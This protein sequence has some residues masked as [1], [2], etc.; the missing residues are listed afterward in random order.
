[1]HFIQMLY[2]FVEARWP[3]D[4]AVRVRGLAGNIV[5]CSWAINFTLTVPLSAQVYKCLSTNL[6]LGVTLRWTIL[7]VA[8]C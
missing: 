6:M 7:L 4:R 1:M 3:P 2:F 8:S 5:L